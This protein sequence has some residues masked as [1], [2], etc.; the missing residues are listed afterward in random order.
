M[1]LS[2]S[3][4]RLEELEK[5]WMGK[6]GRELTPREKFYLAFAESC[7][8]PNQ[9]LPARAPAEK[10]LPR[11]KRWPAKNKSASSS[12]CGPLPRSLRDKA[13]SCTKLTNCWPRELQTRAALQYVAVAQPFR[14]SSYRAGQ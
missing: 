6:L 14:A 1:S 12:T 10:T 11:W 9:S 3:E 7:S 4:T 2:E 5:R 13:N 8:P